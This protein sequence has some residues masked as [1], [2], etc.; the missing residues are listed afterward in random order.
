MATTKKIDK[1]EIDSAVDTLIQAQKILNNKLILPRVRQ[2]F[3]EKQRALA[4]VALELKVATKQRAIR[5]K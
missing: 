3:K 5:N 2:A 1:W 4:E